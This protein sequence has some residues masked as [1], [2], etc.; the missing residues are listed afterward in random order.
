MPRYCHDCAIALGLLRPAAPTTLVDTQYQLDKYL[1]H[2]AP[3][4]A[5]NF[6]TVFTAPGSL[7]YEKCLVSAIA[8]GHVLVDSQNRVNV[9]WVA[10]EQTGIALVDGKFV[11]PTH[12]VKVVLHHDDQKI[13]AFPIRTS[14][15]SAQP[16]ARCGRLVPY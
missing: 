7:T 6:N 10:S 5:Y 3:Q 2:T 8:S 11:G 15:L 12:A 1:K 4:S 9:C 14:D 16:C 13:H